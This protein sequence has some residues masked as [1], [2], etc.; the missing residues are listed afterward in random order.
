MIFQPRKRQ[1]NSNHSTKCMVK[2]SM[3]LSV[4]E[5]NVVTLTKT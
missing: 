5:D 3:E 4:K 1:K 2:I